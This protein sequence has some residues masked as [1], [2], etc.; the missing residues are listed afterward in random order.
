MFYTFLG[1]LGPIFRFLFFTSIALFF[2]PKDPLGPDFKPKQKNMENLSN[3][4]LVNDFGLRSSYW[5]VLGWRLFI[6][7][8][9]WA[10]A[11]HKYYYELLVF[12]PGLPAPGA[13]KTLQGVFLYMKS[14]TA[15]FCSVVWQL[16]LSFS[17]LLSLN[18][19]FFWGCSMFSHVF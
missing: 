8:C 19:L 6:S 5:L 9:C 3:K 4:R 7:T 12:A 10:C 14:L 13:K 15:H 16:F 1:V 18:S 17:S 2:V 11:G